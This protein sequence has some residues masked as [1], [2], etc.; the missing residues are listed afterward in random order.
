MGRVRINGQVAQ[1]GDRIR[2]NDQIVLNGRRVSLRHAEQQQ[3]RV[4]VYNKP[5]GELVTRHDPEGRPTVFRHLPRLRQARW[6]SV[7]RLDLNSSGVL[8]LTTHGELANRLMHP[9]TLIERE[10]L[11]RIQG[12]LSNEERQQLLSGVELDD[13]PARFSLIERHAGEG[14]NRWYRV[15]L[16]EGR[17][18]EIRRMFEVLDKPVSR[19]LRTR[20]GNIILGRR[21]ATGK[22]RELQEEELR[23]LQELTGVPLIQSQPPKRKHHGSHP[24][25]KKRYGGPSRRRS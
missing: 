5:E 18:R 4:I 13:G 6:I 22:H 24:L 9:S 25:S 10:Y 3:N 15:I 12:E 1:P 16:N 20:Y 8:L 23:G 2:V 19:L 11:V 17:N 21:Q 14:F 7:G